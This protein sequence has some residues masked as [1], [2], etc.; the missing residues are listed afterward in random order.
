MSKSKGN[1]VSPTLL[2]EEY[3]VDTLRSAIMFGA[4]PEHDLNFDRNAVANTG[5]Y[6]LRVRKLASII[7][8]AHSTKPFNQIL[9]EMQESDVQNNSFMITVLKLL[10]DYEVKIGKA[11]FFHV[12]FARLMELTNKI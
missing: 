4:P 1:G 9:T 7:G 2:A 3:G 12:A 5:A 6:L 10:V 11:R 8:D